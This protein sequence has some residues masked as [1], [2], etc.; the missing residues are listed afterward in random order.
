MIAEKLHLEKRNTPN[1]VMK[2][3]KALKSV[4]KFNTLKRLMAFFVDFQR[5]PRK[6]RSKVMKSIQLAERSVLSLHLAKKMR[7]QKKIAGAKLKTGTL[8]NLCK[9]KNQ[10]P[11]G[12]A[13]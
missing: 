10:H 8:E 2:S 4:E 13:N 7:L 12:E 3:W 11:P 1:D 6:K 9:N 5:F